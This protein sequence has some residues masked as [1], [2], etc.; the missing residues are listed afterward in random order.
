MMRSRST[1]I[2]L[3]LCC[4]VKCSIRKIGQMLGI[5]KSAVHRQKKRLSKETVFPSHISGKQG[6]AFDSF[7]DYL[8]AYFFYLASRVV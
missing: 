7:A 4:P 3:K 2:F 8:L 1:R 6:K 5:S